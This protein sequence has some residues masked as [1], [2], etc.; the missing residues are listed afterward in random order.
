MM[1]IMI[2]IPLLLMMMLSLSSVIAEC[3]IKKVDKCMLEMAI[4]GDTEL[5]FPTNQTAMNDRCK[6]MRRLEYCVKD[7]SKKCLT[8][9]AGQTTSV[10]MYGITKTNKAFCSKKRQQSY[11]RIGRCVNSDPQIFS[12]IMNRLTKSFHAIKSYPK[13]SMR[14]PLVCW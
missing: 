3:D 10:L 13:E 6:Q 11:L 14:I 8:K 1:I 2:K 4:I 12:T 5:R 9:R 7:Y